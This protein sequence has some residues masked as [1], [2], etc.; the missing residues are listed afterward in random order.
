MPLS[1]IVLATAGILTPIAR[2]RDSP[3]MVIRRDSPSEVVGALP[4]QLAKCGCDK[5][6]WTELRN[7]GRSSLKRMIRQGTEEHKVRD[8]IE[9]MRR[10]VNK[11]TAGNG[12]NAAA[13][14]GGAKA[15]LKGGYRLV[16]NVPASFDVAAAE[17]MIEAR[18]AARFQKD[19][20]QADEIRAQLLAQDVKVI[21]HPANRSWRVLQGTA[22]SKSRGGK[23]VSRSTKPSAVDSCSD[24]PVSLQQEQAPSA[25]ADVVAPTNPKEVEAVSEGKQVVAGAAAA[26][27]GFEWGATF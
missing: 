1:V 20:K 3:R 21:D 16:G 26:P 2:S 23:S 9:A 7:S 10:R 17:A 5:E 15:R 12:V 14:K 6:L 19:Y 13:A 8:Q 18:T 25:A 22:G 24:P 4:P 27:D 11:S